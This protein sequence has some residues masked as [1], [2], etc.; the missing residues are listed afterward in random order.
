M[1]L[2]EVKQVK[3][4][5]DDFVDLGSL[6]DALA[7]S[8]MGTQ[9]VPQKQERRSTP[10]ATPKLKQAPAAQTRARAAQVEMPPEAGEKLSFLQHLDLQDEISDEEAARRA[11]ATTDDGYVP[12]PEP[13]DI[14][15]MPA[16]INKEISAS[17]PVEPEWHQVK[18]LPG[19]L[20]QGIRAMGRQ[21]FST[22]T[23][24]PIEDIQVIANVGG[25]GPNEVREINAVAGWLKDN[26]QRDTDGEMDFERS[27]P[28]YKADFQIYKAQ[29]FTFML[30]QDFA[31]RYIYSWPST[32]EQGTKGA[33]RLS[34]GSERRRL[35]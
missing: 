13:T 26:A 24:T 14:E 28:D 25:R 11:G 1:K 33:E 10:A 22:F 3:T 23:E 20:Q 32:N 5:T 2:F 6:R 35:R 27:M 30:V 17:S 9:N 16:V 21:V 34:V 18:H 31:G 7:Q 29:G 12:E 8:G 19:Y 4:A 15:N